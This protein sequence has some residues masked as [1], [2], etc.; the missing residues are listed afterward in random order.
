MCKFLSSL[1]GGSDNS[2]YLAILRDQQ[3][4]AKRAN[5]LAVDAADEARKRAEAAL[6]NPADSESAR[7]ASESR[8]RRLLQSRGPFLSQGLGTAPVAYKSLLGQ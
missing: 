2:E 8:Q 4:Q 7:K 3:A 5:D 6:V 1:F